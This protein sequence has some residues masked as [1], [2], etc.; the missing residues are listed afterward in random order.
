MR[1][2]LLVALLALLAGCG[3]GDGGGPQDAADGLPACSLGTS[4]A[5]IEQKLFKGPKCIRCHFRPGLFPTS[6][7]LVSEGLAARVVGKPAET[8]PGKGKCAGRLL[9]DPNDPLSGVFVE[10][11]S[12]NPSCGDSMP[13][14]E[15]P[16][17]A[18]EISCVKRWT[19][20]AVQGT[21]G[22]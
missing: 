6:L 5:D 12:P 17:S 16:L 19:L 21:A 13:Q 22:N 1:P 20:M 4:M 7:D 18:D 11:V 2:S 8:D 10:K 15:T 9:V 3:G 14:G